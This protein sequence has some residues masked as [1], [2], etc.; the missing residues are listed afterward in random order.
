MDSVSKEHAKWLINIRT[1][2]KSYFTVW[3]YDSTVEIGGNDT[4]L[5]VDENK[6]VVIYKSYPQVYEA[7]IEKLVPFF[8][9]E[10]LQDWARVS[11][12]LSAD[13]HE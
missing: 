1:S 5:L 3:G 7:I 9:G 8:H 4:K 2:N 6:N 12:L 10:K 13:E 11:Q